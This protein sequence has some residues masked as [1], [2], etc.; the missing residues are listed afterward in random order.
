MSEIHY[1]QF[2]NIVEGSTRITEES[3]TRI[4]EQDD[5]RITSDVS[6]NTAESTMVAQATRIPLVTTQYIKIS[7]Q[8]VRVSHIYVKYNGNWVE[9]NTIYKNVNGV[10]KRVK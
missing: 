5:V 9:P 10:W 2:E 1:A 6:S 3:D 8:W 4:T 7:G